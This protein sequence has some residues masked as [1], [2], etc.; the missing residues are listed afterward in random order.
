MSQTQD[1][2]LFITAFTQSN[3]KQTLPKFLPPEP[4]PEDINIQDM[5]RKCE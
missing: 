2:P 5:I 1:D 4:S 3:K